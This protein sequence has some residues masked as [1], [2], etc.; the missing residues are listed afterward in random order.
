MRAAAATNLA[1]I[2]VQQE[3]TT[4]ARTV[5]CLVYRWETSQKSCGSAAPPH[6]PAGFTWVV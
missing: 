3:A 1:E 5:D 4:A 6:V 2:K